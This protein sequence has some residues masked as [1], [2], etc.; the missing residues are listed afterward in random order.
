MSSTLISGGPSRSAALARL[1]EQARRVCDAGLDH[2]PP[3]Q[4]ELYLRIF[5]QGI[6][7]GLSLHPRV[8][9]RKQSDATNLLERLRDRA[10]EYLRFTRDRHV[11]ATNNQDERDLRPVKTQIKIS[12]CHQ[13]ETGAAAWPAVRSYISTAAKHGL[14]VYTTLRAAMTGE[15]WMPP[16][17]RET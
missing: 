2:I 12:G 8:P 17:A 16:I 4:G 9:G 11:P 15:L 5:H 7:V 10:E 3:E 6:A 1:I 13:S 14:S